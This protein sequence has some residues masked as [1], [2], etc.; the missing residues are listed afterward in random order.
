MGCALLDVGMYRS[1]GFVGEQGMVDVCCSASIFDVDGFDCAVEY[2][3]R[4]D[5]N[6]GRQWQWRRGGW[7][8]R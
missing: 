2:E 4:Y 3:E 5:R 8:G 1:C 6:G 7:C